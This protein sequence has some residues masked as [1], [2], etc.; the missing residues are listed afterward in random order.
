MALSWSTKDPND[1]DSF[2]IN[3]ATR[4]DGDLISTSDWIV[5]TGLTEDSA[6]NT[7]TTTTIWL[8]S[9]TD[10]DDYEITN[11]ITTTGGRTLDQTVKLKVRA[12]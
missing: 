8:S 7:T 1:V 5:P 4:L 3:W 12:K 2:G 10:G 9:G 6:S 11:R